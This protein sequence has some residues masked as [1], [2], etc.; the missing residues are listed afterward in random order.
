MFEYFYNEIFR[1]V[2]IGFGS[3]FNGIEIEHKNESDNTVSTLRVPLA[4]GPTQKFLARIEQQANLNKGTQMSLPR[5]SFEFTDLQYDP[6]RKSTQTQQFVV[7]NSTGSEIKKGYVPVPYNMTIQLS[8][9]TKLNDDMLQI[10]E[11]ILPYFQP[12]YNL[13][14]NFLGDF[15][16]KR[17]I[18][19]QLEGI[20]MEDDYEGNF[21]TRRALVYTLTFTAKTF[22]FGPLSDVSGDIIK[23]VTVGY[24]SGSA[25]PGLRN[26]ERDLT[27]RVVPRAV[28][29]YD[30]SYVTTIS[31]NV[32]IEEKVIEVADASQLSA[33]SYIQI[34]KEEMYIEKVSGNKLTVKRGQDTSTAAEHVLGSGVATITAADNNLIEIGD[35][36][37]FDGTVF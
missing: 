14:I 4:Y 21:E 26:P 31:E 17:D 28:Q 30:D 23:K 16:E 2:I 7:K 18:P 1:S 6:T 20:S 10:V 29:D 15:K 27:Y 32:G 25:G 11:Q 19:I 34:G 35:D 12:S 37:G 24:V 5:M 36:F 33:A 8:I 22:L 13:P 9:M 3:M